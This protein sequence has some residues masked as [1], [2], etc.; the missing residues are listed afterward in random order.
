MKNSIFSKIFWSY[1]FIIIF[2]ALFLFAFSFNL[3]KRSYIKTT[4]KNLK[5][6]AVALSPE[7]MPFLQNGDYS[8]LDKTVKKLGK[9]I[10]VRITVVLPD[11]KVAGD[12]EKN[13][14]FM[15]NHK[16]RPE[17]IEALK[18]GYGSSIRYSAT[19]REEM[20]YVALPLFGEGKLKGFLR[21]SVFL[22]DINA[23][24][25]NMKQRL[26]LSVVF[27]TFLALIGALFVAKSLSRPVIE[28]A[29]ASE[30]IASGNFDVS[31]ESFGKD[32][33]GILAS[34]FNNMA[35]K[36][37]ELFGKLKMNEEELTNLISS[38]SEALMVIDENGKITLTNQAFEDFFGGDGKGKYFY[39][40]IRDYR[41]GEFVDTAKEGNADFKEIDLSGKTFLCS[42]SRV[43][44]K[45]EILVILRDV[46]ELK[47][48]E[49]IKKDFVVNASH[50]LRTPLTA[51]K[52]YLETLEDLVGEEGKHYL[53]VVL[54]NTERLTN[55]V[56]DLLLL[57]ESEE[58]G[59]KITL[60]K[61]PVGQM[62]LEIVSMFKTKAEK[63]GLKIVFEN[64]AKECFVEG[65][66]FKLE[67]VFI[68]LIDN[69][70][71]YT[72]SGEVKVSLSENENGVEVKVSDTGIGIPEKYIERIFERF[73]VVDKSRSKKTGGTGL[74]LSIVKHIVMLH[75]GDIEVKSVQ[76]KGTVFTVFLP[77]TSKS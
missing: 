76:N 4:S 34:S 45:K 3:V 48:L 5:K 6:L 77:K 41:F 56:N 16:N 62:L 53:Q 49:K 68:N 36:L 47:K 63:K 27:I 10:G 58:K 60:D 32:E 13:P 30:K 22:R 21:I 69:A 14:E 31:V 73:F 24:L 11:G 15:E 18:K 40:I 67:Q 43:K 9:K 55:I 19:V 46:S 7:I 28:L 57:S 20:L 64:N 51:I 17:L 38:M 50:E 74:G 25:K 42:V 65:D 33:I 12:S 66:R 70:V 54:N 8:M 59:L 61:I 23:F 37:R 26:F 72:D 44:S 71:K 35:G 75:G 2:T 52:G 29:E 1:F 39:E